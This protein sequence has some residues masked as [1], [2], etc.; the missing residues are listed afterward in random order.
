M[1]D[2][3]MPIALGLFCL[4]VLLRLIFWKMPKP[5]GA[6]CHADYGR[7]D[8]LADVQQPTIKSARDN[9]TFESIRREERV[10]GK[11]PAL[12]APFGKR[13]V[14]PVRKPTVTL[15]PR[16][17]ERANVQRRHE[18]RKPLT[19]EGVK[20]AIATASTDTR[21]PN[22]TNDWLTYLILYE[23]FFADHQ[24]HATGGV[25]GFTIDPNLP[26]NG[27]GGE[28]SGAGASGN[29][30]SAS[31]PTAAVATDISGDMRPNGVDD[32][33]VRATFDTPSSPSYSPDPT[34]SYTPDPTPSYSA[35]DTSSSFSSSDSSSSISVDT[36]PM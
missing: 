23:C 3:A 29:W 9:I 22:T 31:A 5:T 21:Q 32:P 8:S 25:G 1:F 12:G 2:Y 27:Q 19:R 15:T 18:G 33:G 14:P 30:T 24:S 6:Q 4:A 34:P 28:Y 10:L 26:Y 13:T 17:I 11:H 7:D 36:S 16:M 35:P 20:A